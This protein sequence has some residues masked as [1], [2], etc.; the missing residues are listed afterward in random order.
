MVRNWSTEELACLQAAA[1]AQI[2]LKVMANALGRTVSAVNKVL[3]RHGIR[4]QKSRPGRRKGDS[5]I[6]SQTMRAKRDT[7][8]MESLVHQYLGKSF[9]T[10]CDQTPPKKNELLK[11][12]RQKDQSYRRKKRRDLSE[13]PHIRVPLEIVASWAKEEGLGFHKLERT[14][15]R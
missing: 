10:R 11:I 15:R 3:A 12:L 4:P 6:L 8:V 13:S 14:Q 9:A 2:Q 7:E 5:S 1:Q